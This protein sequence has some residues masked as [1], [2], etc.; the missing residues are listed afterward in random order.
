VAR[1][2]LW[3]FAV[4]VLVG[5]A[6]CISLLPAQAHRS[7]RKL[8]LLVGVNHYD[9]RGFD[10]LSYAE[11]DAAELADALKKAGFQVVLLT[12]SAADDNPLRATRANIDKQLDALLTNA[13]KDDVVLVG[14]CGHG[15]QLKDEAFF[16]PVDAVLDRP[17]SLLSLSYLIDDVLAVKGGKNLVLV[18]ACRDAPKDAGR[19]R[20]ARGVQG[21]AM[22][23]PEATAVLFSCR[24]G[25]EA[26]ENDRLK[27]GLFTYCV[28]EVLK[29]KGVAEKEI[30]WSSLVKYVEDRMDADDLRKLLPDGQLQQP[31][32]SSNNV[33][34]V[35]LAQVDPK[36]NRTE[37][38]RTTA[39]QPTPPKPETLVERQPPAS[40]PSPVVPPVKNPTPPKPAPRVERER[41]LNLEL[42][43]K[44][45][46][47]LVHIPAAGKSFWMGSPRS[48]ENRNEDE[49]QHQV[50]FTHDYWLAVTETTQA[51][52]RAVMGNNPSQSAG[53]D[54]P[55]EGVSWVYAC[56]FCD[57]LDEVFRDKGLVFRL[58]T[59]AEW[60]YAA[61]GGA[62]EKDS[63]PFHFKDGPTRWLTSDLANFVGTQ[64]Y[65][66]LDAPKGRDLGRT[67]Q[68]ASYSA[69]RFGLYDMHGNVMEW[70][71]DRY[72]PYSNL[73]TNRDPYQIEGGDQGVLR[74]GAF[75]TA[76]QYCRAA[77]R[78]KLDVAYG[79]N[80]TGFRVAC[81]PRK[82]E[83]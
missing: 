73:K 16:C 7:P 6:A 28:L 26:F 67:V 35:V 70:C 60:E 76:G 4:V 72:G 22:T 79:G 45:K 46:F 12:G 1:S 24:A 9:R 68:V 14:L 43:G 47:K 39:Q 10:D 2:L 58:P 31:F 80:F 62:T 49:E 63:R 33:G 52:Y 8:A 38:G 25:Q 20:R 13:H 29:G 30:T 65:P 36:P 82:L 18:D 34:R 55:V 64:P 81:L 56:K 32:L 50:E 21:R 83:R 23:L 3:R 37:Q 75:F 69:N 77:S 57:R 71:Y 44:V 41:E 5:L 27:H 42:R 48:E 17:E 59:E 51:Q 15:H 61:R 74:G 40:N 53:D 78:Y 11:A 54:L 66:F 19:G